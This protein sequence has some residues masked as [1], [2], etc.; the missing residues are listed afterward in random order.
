MISEVLKGIKTTCLDLSV[1]PT[2]VAVRE[3]FNLLMQGFRGDGGLL[4]FVIL[5]KLDC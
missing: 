2:F 1:V 5:Y 4:P 3:R